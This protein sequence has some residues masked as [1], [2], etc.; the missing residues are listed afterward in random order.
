MTQGQNQK[1]NFKAR[2]TYG[3]KKQGILNI[4]L[5]IRSLYNKVNGIKMLAKREKPH[6]L[7]ITEAELRKSCQEMQELLST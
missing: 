2:M 4:Q 6:I 5:N 7:G 3:N 1:S